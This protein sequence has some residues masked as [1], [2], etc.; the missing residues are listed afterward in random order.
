MANALELM[1]KADAVLID[2]VLLPRE[3]LPIKRP[4][5][6]DWEFKFAFDAYLAS[7]FLPGTAPGSVADI[8][9]SGAYLPEHRAA[10][11]RRVARESL[12]APE[13][14][15][16]LAYHREMK[17][18]VLALM[19]EEGLDALAYPTSMVTPRS[20]ENPPGGWAPELAANS[21]FPALTLPIGQAQ[22]GPYIGLEFLARSHGE[23]LLLGIA[24]DLEERY[25]A[26][27]R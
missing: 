12:D 5:V 15:E 3:I 7:H 14:K 10:L 18:A 4:H 11:E 6:V 13:Y 9:A 26:L 22:H 8:L 20:L 16:I 19:D 2:P 25:R 21:G 27:K 1:A 23:S 17:K 24:T